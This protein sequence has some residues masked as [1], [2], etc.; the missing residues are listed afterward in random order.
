MSTRAKHGIEFGF[1]G[2]FLIL[3]LLIG[4]GIQAGGQP[5]EIPLNC[6]GGRLSSGTRAALNRMNHDFH[7][8]KDVW[9]IGSKR[10]LI[11]D[12]NGRVLEYRCS[13]STLWLN[14]Q[15]VISRVRA[16]NFEFRDEWGG[17]L[18]HRS[19]NCGRVHTIVSTLRLQDRPSEVF[20]ISRTALPWNGNSGRDADTAQIAF[21]QSD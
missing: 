10:V 5:E 8:A 19:V 13:G 18:T 17:L 20:V 3:S 21:R 6:Y 12:R 4:R 15:P 9:S 7:E 16:L 14:R 1:L 2:T 11:E